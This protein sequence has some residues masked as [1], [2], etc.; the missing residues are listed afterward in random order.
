LNQTNEGNTTV[1]S[2]KVDVNRKLTLQLKA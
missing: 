2:Y 1:V